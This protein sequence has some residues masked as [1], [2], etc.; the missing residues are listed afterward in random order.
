MLVGTHEET[1]PLARAAFGVS[2]PNRVL[3]RVA[4]GEAL[5]DG[6][7]ALG[8]GKIDGKPTAYVCAG[9]TCSLPL[10]EAGALEAELWRVRAG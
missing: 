5:P 10:T 1:A 7:P 6:H 2:M 4:D 3:M 9:E 8:K